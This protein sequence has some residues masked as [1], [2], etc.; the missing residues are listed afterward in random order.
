MTCRNLESGFCNENVHKIIEKMAQ[1]RDKKNYIGGLFGDSTKYPILEGNECIQYLQEHLPFHLP[2]I[3]YVLSDVMRKFRDFFNDTVYILDIGSGPATVPLAF[4]RLSVIR[5]QHR[6]NLKITTVEPSTGFNDMISIFKAT[7]TNKSVEIVNMLDYKISDDD[8]V[9]DESMFETGYDWIIIANSISA[10]CRDPSMS[11]GDKI[12]SVNKLLN[13][14]I[15]MLL[16]HS[17]N[18]ELLLTIIETGKTSYFDFIKYLTDIERLFF[19][20]LRIKKTVHTINN[21]SIVN[22]E[23]IPNRKRGKSKYSID[24]PEIMNCRFYRTKYQDH[25]S[26][27]INSKSLLLELR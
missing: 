21:P 15:C 17:N 18:N 12:A 25:Y 26:P 1:R 20:E 13:K 14:L 8:F 11:E 23:K 19:G 9:N 5:F 6:Y 2:Q 4:C 10:F 24:V 3:E 27:Y 22:F 16:P 7:N